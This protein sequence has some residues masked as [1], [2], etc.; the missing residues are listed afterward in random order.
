MIKLDYSLQTPEERKALVEQILAENPD[1]NNYY[2]EILADY[3]ILC[4][5][6]QERKEKK[7]LTENRMSTV[8]K[9]ETSFEGLVSQFENG[10]DG[11]YNL[12]TEDKNMIFQHKVSITERDLEEIPL[13]KQIK[14]AIEYWEKQAKT[15]TGKEAYIIRKTIIDLRKDQY[16]VKNAFRKPIVTTHQN[17]SK[18]NIPLESSERF[19]NGEVVAEGVSLCDPQICSLI[20]CNYS[21]LKQEGY[22]NFMGDT[23]YLMEDFDRISTKALKNQPY[24][25]RLVELKIDGLQNVDIQQELQKEFGI[26][27]SVEYISTLWRNKIP[28]LIASAAQDEWLDHYFLTEAYGKYKKC[29]KCGQIKLALPKYFTVNNTSKDKL[30]SICKDCRNKKR[31]VGGKK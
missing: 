12:V 7:I 27:H 16:I 19:E 23:W 18:V 10:E 29:S 30:Y 4:M 28:Q 2:L 24:Y 31:K 5:E 25:E 1:L 11:I 26:K 21:K 13:L 8:N 20:L 9:R 15:A 14:E 17:F 3:L 6:K 22:G